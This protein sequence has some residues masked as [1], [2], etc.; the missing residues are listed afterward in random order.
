MTM[1]MDMMIMTLTILMIILMAGAIILIDS[2]NHSDCWGNYAV[3]LHRPNE[4]YQSMLMI[5]LG[6]NP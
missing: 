6:L 3:R 5:V 4:P 2:D 1:T